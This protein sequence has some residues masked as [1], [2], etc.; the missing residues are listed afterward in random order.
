MGLLL[1]LL[2]PAISPAQTQTNGVFRQLWSDLFLPDDNLLYL[3]N[4]YQ[5]QL[6]PDNPNTN[7]TAIFTSFETEVNSPRNYYGQR[8][9]TY[10]VPPTDGNYTFWIASADQANLFLSSDDNPTNKVLIAWVNTFTDPRQWTKE[11]NQQSAPIAL[12]HG[13]PYYLEAIMEKSAGPDNLAAAWQPPGS[14]QTNVIPGANLQVDL[15]PA[16]GT[17]PSDTT[18]TEL[19]T[20]TFV[21]RVL[22]FVSPSFQ[23]QQGPAFANIPGA[24][25]A[26]LTLTNVALASSN[27]PYRCVLSNPYGTNLSTIAILYVVP[28]TNPPTLAVVA[29]T[30]ASN[31]L[32]YFSKAVDPVTAANSLNYTVGGGISVFSA[33]M[34]S[35]QGV[36]LQVSPLTVNSNYTVTVNNVRD[37]AATPNTIAPN[38]QA[39]F[40]AQFF[41]SSDVAS[42]TPPGSVTPQAGG[43]DV[44][45]GGA[46]IGGISDQF[47]F[48][49]QASAGDFDVEVQ[50]Q[51]LSVSDLWAKAGLMARET[52]NP[53]SRFAG[54]FVTPGMA[55]CFFESRSSLSN[56]SAMS[57]TFPATIP[58]QWLRLQRVGNTFNG[59]AGIDGSNWV[60]LGSV[61]LP[62]GVVYV[63]FAVTSHNP[64]QLGTA[65]FRNFATAIGGMIAPVVLPYEPLQAC[66]RRTGLVISEIMYKPAPRTDGNIIEYIEL[67]NSNPFYEDISGHS[68]A[69]D[70]NF[71]FPSNTVLQAG[72]FL[73]VAASPASVQSVYGI[74]N[75]TGPYIGT[76]RKSGLV[77][78]TDKYRVILLEVPYSNL[79]PWPVAAD[80]SGHSI[81]LARPSYGAADGRAWAISDLVGGSPGTVETY[82]P[83]PLRNVVIN[84][85]LAHSDTN[86]LDY[87]ELYNH[88]ATA[89]DITGCVLTDN[90]L[91]NKFVITNLTILPAGGFISFDETQ[92]GF[93]LNAAGETIFFKNPDGSRI[94]DAVAFE[95]Q[96]LG[97]S[98]GRV[99]DGASDFYPL[100]A[101]SPGAPNGAML[102]RDIV[103][104]EI[105]Y[106]PISGNDDDQFLELYNKGTNTVSLAL[107]KFTAGISF[108][109]PTNASL[110]PD[111]YLV[112]ARNRTN[113]WAHYPS[114]NAGNTLGDYTGKLPHGGGRI[115]LAMPEP[116]VTVSAVGVRTT[117]T[118]YV[119]ADEVTY[120]KGGRWGQWSDAG[121]SSL[122]L[123]NPNT[124]HRLA[125]NWADS[126]E[127]AKSSWTN[128]E[129]TGVLAGGRSN[130]LGSTVDLVQLGLLSAGECVVD[131]VEVRPVA[132]GVPGLNL[133]ANPN[134]EAGLVNWEPQGDHI[135]SGLETN[136]AYAGVQSLHLRASDGIFTG[137][138][139]VQGTLNA[140]TLTNGAT[141]TL[142]LKARWVRGWP[143]LLFRLRG[144]GLELTGAMPVP[145][146][147]GTPGQRNS[148][149]VT[150]AGPAIYE[151]KHTPSIPPASQPVVVTARF[152]DVRGF[153]PTLLYRIDTAVNPTPTYVSVP[154]VDD[155]T[156]GDAVAGD[157]IYSATIPAQ[158][159]GTVVAFLIQ[160][161]DPLGATTIFPSDL[162][163][164]SGIPRECVVGFGDAVSGGQF[165]QH[166]VWMTRNWINRWIGLGG[167][168]NE[169]H[170]GTFADGGGRLIY[171]WVGRVAGSPYHQYTGGPLTVCGQHWT[172]P[173]DDMMLGSTSFNKQHVPGNG[174]LDDNTL[175]REQMS[176]WMTRQIGMPWNYRRYYVLYVNGNRIGP[177]MED[178]QV[179]GAELLKQ[180][181]PNDNNGFLYKNNAWFE[182]APTLGGGPQGGGSIGFENVPPFCLMGRFTTTVNGETNQYNLALYRWMYWIR[183]SPDSLNNFS[184]VYNLVSAANTPASSPAYYANMEAEVDTEEWLRMSALEHVTG[185]WDSFFTKNQWNM[186]LYKPLQGKWTALKWDWNISM[187]GGTSTWGPDGSQLFTSGGYDP[188]MSTFQS[189]P[190]YRRAYLRALKEIAAVAMNNTYADPVMDARY[191]AFVANGIPAYFSSLASPSAALKSW[192]GTMH[193]SILSALTS[194]GV[195]N[196]PFAVQG[197]TLVTNNTNFI[198]LTGTAPVEVKT[199][200][201]NGAAFPVTWTS[202]SAW[203][204]KLALP[205]ATN[206]L[207]LQG[208]DVYGNPVSNMT[209]TVTQ[210]YTGAIPGAPGAV[211][212]N[213]IQYN[214]GP[215]G[216][217]YV[218]LFNTASNY[219]FDLSNWKFNGLGYTFPPGSYI[220]PRSYLVLAADRFAFASAYGSSIPLFDVFPGTLQ[221]D[222][223]TLTLSQ[224]GIL[225][226]PDVIVDKVRYRPA[227]P[228]STNANGTGSS[229]QLTDPNQDNSRPGNWYA[230]YVPAVY[231]PEQVI[232]P[233]T[234]SGWRMVSI[235]GSMGPYKQLY[236]YLSAAGDVYVDDLALVTG[237][238]PAVGSNYIKDG[239]FELALTNGFTAATNCTNSA[240]SAD[241][242]HG[243]NS[244]LHLVMSS[245]GS[246][247]A[248]K[249]LYQ[250]LP[251]TAALNN[252]AVVTLSFWYLVTTNA[253]ELNVK[254]QGNAT[255]S[256]TTNVTP[257]V[258]SGTNIPP[259]LVSGATNYATPG[260]A[261]TLV[262]NLPAFPALWLNEIQPQNLTGLTNSAGGRTPWIELYNIGTNYVPLGGLYLSDSYTNLTNWVFPNGAVI[263][264]GEF[265]VIFADG[266][267]GLSTTNEPH[268]GFVLGTNGGSLALSRL[269]NGKVEVLDYLDYGRIGPDLS[270]GS[271]PDGQP[272]DRRVFAHPTPGGTN[273]GSSVLLPIL[274][275]EWMANNNTTIADPADGRYED[276]F[277]LY[278]ASPDPVIA[279]WLL[280][281][282]HQFQPDQVP[283]P[284]GL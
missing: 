59:Y 118:I 24:T 128:L 175:M 94:L 4:T 255:L 96:D 157:G 46:G 262:T 69:G 208:Y 60:Q 38:S 27:T 173:A 37:L 78:L 266:Q 151:V 234:N 91:S 239:D 203:S 240:Q 244:S 30:G 241:Y 125:Y 190:P 74:T 274:V 20:A 219:T 220:R 209:A 229:L 26:T 256:A 218:E 176:Y 17:Q 278:N 148:Q 180:H 207:S 6:W 11:P 99:P 49:Y 165:G 277:E 276:W 243:G 189:Y 75:V 269:D 168:S 79:P 7:Y 120:S 142:R 52:L 103:I 221:T 263:N 224:P 237:T 100:A 47:Q 228:W 259:Q 194:Q 146:N 246:A 8:L 50:V 21:V 144:N 107:W 87:I 32:V 44:A 133:I 164:N 57:G 186:Y 282:R 66:D 41:V 183:A 136:S 117:N 102:I 198:T 155:G 1:A 53:G 18:V 105:M 212:M 152:H 214:P 206:V 187:G 135:R 22:N 139:S 72:A 260:A 160:A 93:A 184:N 122:E 245:P 65:Q 109:F 172:M 126:D 250:T 265:K 101:R 131:N 12:L 112:V 163:D 159:A 267:V 257:L 15:A 156:G 273:D 45:G 90:A 223:E 252:G 58:N 279:G 14:A 40:T 249:S 197:S 188:A 283:D 36:L 181:W 177:L 71:T 5:N 195:A 174:A 43:V 153:Q 196:V 222:G 166:H 73:V 211:V 54:T 227:L 56:A 149:A 89:V 83:S 110:A 215:L 231:T 251:T 55:G 68:L 98:F 281:D 2:A 233:T 121:G 145:S 115:A 280:P 76:L 106:K 86:L 67:Y 270:Y 226:G 154:M 129:Y 192:I 33:A 204:L 271:Y 113:L 48:N 199:I 191:A 247:S 42:S 147:L 253:Q 28:D 140:N 80:G 132:N 179:P 25:N 35:S 178:S 16:I 213:E 88:S 275:N 272:F 81:F 29:N 3:T 217:P 104:N 171:N 238:T 10:L 82:R 143:E 216:T 169:N 161:Q 141:A 63:G 170:D 162:H 225:G 264:P 39:T 85:F 258:T 130:G 242:K 232:P 19:T 97:V 23:W 31:I 254:V 116:H 158:P 9:R 202:A 64:G 70:I 248:T 13:K 95:A 111:S 193:N 205:G 62:V 268:T 210:L 123:I 114:L 108:T 261:N 138:N 34:S 230:R 236:L 127:T 167:L 284:G 61:T 200:Q 84:E 201:I 119:V 77:Q 92:M 51:G 137:Y 134:F 150:N 185:D 235:T 182:F 124:N